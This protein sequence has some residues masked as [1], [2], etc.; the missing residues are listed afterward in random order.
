MTYIQKLDEKLKYI[1]RRIVAYKR[2]KLM[3]VIIFCVIL[4]FIS[5]V[6]ALDVPDYPKNVFNNLQGFSSIVG[7]FLFGVLVGDVI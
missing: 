2:G 3:L 1:T 4:M 6:L 7:I 5:S